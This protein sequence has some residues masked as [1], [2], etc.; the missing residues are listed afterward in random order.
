MIFRMASFAPVDDVEGVI[1]S[2]TGADDVDAAVSLAVRCCFSGD[3]AGLE[4][5]I[6]RVPGVVSAHDPTFND[7]TALHIAVGEDED[8]LALVLLE[9]GAPPNAVDARQNSASWD[10]LRT[11][12][13]CSMMLVAGSI[14]G[15]VDTRRSKC[16]AIF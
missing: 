10:A 8:A 12:V 11:V 9:A 16:V 14:L 1:E 2:L 5:L 6:K 3:V 13:L 4:E 15:A 7:S